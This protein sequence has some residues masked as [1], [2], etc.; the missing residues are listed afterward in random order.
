MSQADY[1]QHPEIHTDALAGHFFH[2]LTV[3][4]EQLEWQGYVL[5]RVEPGV[6]LVQLF[7]WL[8][9]EPNVRRLVRVERMQNWLFYET[10]DQM[11]YSH[12]HGLAREG[13]PYRKA[14]K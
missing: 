7:E 6:Y 1:P 10:A 8:M 3:E 13:G 14:K 11:A 12:D 4:D 5:G 9:G 2:S